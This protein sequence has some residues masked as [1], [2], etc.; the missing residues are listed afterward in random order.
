MRRLLKFISWIE[1]HPWLTFGATGLI[2][3]LFL[4]GIAVKGLAVESDI[5]NFLPKDNPAVVAYRQA[6][7]TYGSSDLFIVALKHPETIFNTTTLAKF[8]ELEA[9]LEALPGVDSVS[10]PAS[11]DLIYGTETAIV[12]EEAMAVVPQSPEAIALYRERVLKDRNLRGLIVAEEGRAGAII[13]RLLPGADIPA[14]VTSIGELAESYRGPEQVFKAGVEVLRIEAGNSSISDIQKLIPFVF[15]ILVLILYLSFHSV[16][17]V[18]L[19]L[20]V[21]VLSTLWTF[22]TMAFTNQPI[23]PFLVVMPILL[24]AIGAADGIHIL[25]KYYE[26]VASGERDRRRVLAS[27]M[28]EMATPVILT[29]VTTAAGFLGLLTSLM[30]PQRSLGVLSAVGILYAMLLSLTLVPALLSVLPL[31]RPRLRQRAFEDAWLSRLLGGVANKV[32]RRPVLVSVLAVATVFLLALQIPRLAIESQPTKFLGDGSEVVKATHVIDEEFG[33]SLQ[34]AVD[35]RTGKR[36]GLKDP[37]VLQDM[38]ELEAFLVSLPHVG[39]VQSLA[40]VVMQLN[41]TLHASDPAFYAIPDDP[42]MLSQLLLLYSGDLENLALGDFSRGEVVASVADLDTSD[43]LEL[44]EE[45]NTYLQENFDSAEAELVGTVNIIAALVPALTSSQVTSLAVAMAVALLIMRLLLRSFMV[46]LISLIPLAFAIVGEFGIMSL[47]QTPLDFIT[48]MLASI[49]VGVGIDYSI[50]FLSRYYH[51]VKGG[52]SASA[53]YEKTARTVGKGIVYNALAITLSFAVLLLSSFRGN[54]NF[55]WLVMLTMIISSIS[56]LVV[57]PSVL[58]L[59]PR[60][61]N[62]PVRLPGAPLEPS[63]VAV[64]P[65][66]PKLN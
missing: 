4:I 64:S 56:A 29:S 10:G 42:R 41:E 40:K 15:V 39:T 61:M 1:R 31:P 16:R 58:L 20:S 55:G 50:H 8:K 27:T 13:I 3:A 35:V 48:V 54:V 47:T 60:F 26:D 43:T 44:V 62:K 51:E 25:N 32:G 2:T 22:G 65:T 17:G 53:A 24:I 45:V 23:T 18:L 52:Q 21:V 57:I 36:D 63:A 49:A 12:V 30:W 46:S 28:A 59:K 11:A 5:I 7:D 6:R 14:M 66:H 19:P 34:L 9:S 37:A 33:G 38:A